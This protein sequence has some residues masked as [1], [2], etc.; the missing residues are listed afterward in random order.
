MPNVCPPVSLPL[1]A[2]SGKPIYVLSKKKKKK[3]SILYF[4]CIA[5]RSHYNEMVVFPR[6]LLIQGFTHFY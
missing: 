1:R 3:G 2:E 6:R 5:K 4:V